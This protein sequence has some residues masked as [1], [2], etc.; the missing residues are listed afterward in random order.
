MPERKNSNKVGLS[1]RS[2]VK[3]ARKEHPNICRFRMFERD[4][5]ME[6]NDTKEMR[7]TWERFH[8]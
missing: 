1:G 7:S 6:I 2:F 4:D 3:S 8:R 5:V